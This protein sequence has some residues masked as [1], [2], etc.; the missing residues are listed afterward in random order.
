M[1][2]L[3]PPPESIGEARAL[4]LVVH[5]YDA[6]VPQ[7][8]KHTPTNKA[9]KESTQTATTRGREQVGGSEAQRTISAINIGHVKGEQGA[10]VE[11]PRARSEERK[12]AWAGLERPL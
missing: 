5:T 8:H 12:G 2:L 10:K 3:P 7:T 4:V 11:G 9:R 1:S 6:S